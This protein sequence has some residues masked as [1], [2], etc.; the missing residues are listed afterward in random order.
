[1]AFELQFHLKGAIGGQDFRRDRCETFPDVVE[2]LKA[3]QA[4]GLQGQEVVV[5]R[6]CGATAELAPEQ[7][8]EL[9]TYGKVLIEDGP[10]SA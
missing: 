2:A 6:L 7:R 10:V 3:E 4:H 5:V 9:A 1:M 8:A